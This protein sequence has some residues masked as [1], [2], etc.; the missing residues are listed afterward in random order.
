MGIQAIFLL[1]LALLPTLY[2]KRLKW[3][4]VKGRKLRFTK[5]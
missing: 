5:L 3:S 2:Y 1:S 4:V